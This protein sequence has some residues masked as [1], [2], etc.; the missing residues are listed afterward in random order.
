MVVFESFAKTLLI[1]HTIFA[2]VL[3]GAMTHNFFLMINYFRGNINRLRLHNRYVLYGF[4]S[5]IFT[6]LFTGVLIYPTFRVRVRYDYLDKSLPW[7]TG[8]FEIKEHWLSVAL[9][10]FI[11][12]Y[13]LNRF[14]DLRRDRHLVKMYS[15]LGII[16]SIIIWYATVASFIIGSYKS[17]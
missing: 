2:V 6:Y 1:L 15:I 12:Y 17:I 5:F 14:L 9:V 16:L 11:A 10:I 7:V 8:L 3:V 13:L 4:V